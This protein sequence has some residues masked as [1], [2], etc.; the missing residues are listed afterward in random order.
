MNKICTIQLGGVFKGEDIG[1]DV[2]ELTEST[3]N[4]GARSLIYWLCKFVQEVAN[5]SGGQY[6]SQTPYN[7]YCLWL[8]TFLSGE[9]W[10][11]CI[12]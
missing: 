10:R 11:E 5:K 9:K 8:K 12:N 7:N 2:Q 4:E 3:E 6:P 1:L